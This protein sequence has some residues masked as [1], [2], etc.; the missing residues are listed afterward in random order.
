MTSILKLSI[1]KYGNVE[2]SINIYA[3]IAI[4]ILSILIKWCI[5][6]Y[7]K[8]GIKQIG[9]D[10]MNLGSEVERQ[11][12]SKYS[13]KERELAYKIWF[14]MESNSMGQPY[15]EDIHAITDLHETWS[16]FFRFTRETI[17]N[18]PAGNMK[19]RLSE[20]NLASLCVTE[21]NRNLKPYLDRWQARYKKWYETAQTQEENISL[22]PQE[23]QKKFDNYDKMA[24]DIQATNNEI[25]KFKEL[26][27]EIAFKK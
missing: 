10:A 13:R 19:H 26:L 16:Q 4:C 17:Q 22:T 24:A 11:I 6:K 15:E 27:Y 21:L 14:E 23:L 3:A 18:S 25:L 7:K 20:K 1:S 12:T 8:K 9:I 5:Q 2:F